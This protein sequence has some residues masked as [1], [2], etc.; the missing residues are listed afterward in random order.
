MVAHKTQ[1][2]KIDDD[3]PD[4]DAI[5]IE[6][7]ACSVRAVLKRPPEDGEK[8]LVIGTGVAGFPVDRCAEVMLEEITRFLDERD[9][10]IETVHLVLYDDET[11][12]VFREIREQLST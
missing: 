11:T 8:V 10:S 5:L 4:E 1:L 6:P 3:I 12:Q 9:T 2:I 7:T